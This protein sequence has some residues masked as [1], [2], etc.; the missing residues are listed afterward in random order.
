M[1]FFFKWKTSV[2][3][4]YLAGRCSYSCLVRSL[5]TPSSWAFF[6]RSGS[7]LV[8]GGRVCPG[9]LPCSTVDRLMC[10]DWP[11]GCSELILLFW[12]SFNSLS[13]SASACDILENNARRG[14]LESPSWL[15][16]LVSS[17]TE[18]GIS[19]WYKSSPK[20]G[21]RVSGLVSAVSGTSA[22]G[23]KH[24]SSENPDHRRLRF[25]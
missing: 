14:W 13:L 22:S 17:P 2:S 4:S 12:R 5:T 3:C 16:S 6:A 15:I 25:P 18:F 23:R 10:S 1:C 19:T 24:R 21:L 9:A 20:F 8:S 11:S 7:V